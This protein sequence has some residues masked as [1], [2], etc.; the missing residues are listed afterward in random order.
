MLVLFIMTKKQLLNT[1]YW[2]C[3][4]TGVANPIKYKT[5]GQRLQIDIDSLNAETLT[6]F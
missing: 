2:Y 6:T 1:H 5:L 3:S 4:V